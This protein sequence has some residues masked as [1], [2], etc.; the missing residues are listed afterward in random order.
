[1]SGL[2]ITSK[3]TG[4]SPGSRRATNCSY[5]S[6]RHGLSLLRSVDMCSKR[7]GSA[8]RTF[9]GNRS[10]SQNTRLKRK[11]LSYEAGETA[12]TRAE[13]STLTGR[14]KRQGIFL[15]GRVGNKDHRQEQDDGKGKSRRQKAKGVKHGKQVGKNRRFSMYMSL[16]RFDVCTHNR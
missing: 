7:S 8:R 12:H 13:R 3:D 11:A 16:H 14:L 1:M 2:W 5:S 6:Y 9:T 15:R 10:A 4:P